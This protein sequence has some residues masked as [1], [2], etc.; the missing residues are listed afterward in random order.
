MAHNTIACRRCRLPR[1]VSDER[2]CTWHPRNRVDCFPETTIA[3]DSTYN[4]DYEY[5]AKYAG[6]K[7]K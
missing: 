2:E 7:E 4:A 3:E 5:A 1:V 6:H